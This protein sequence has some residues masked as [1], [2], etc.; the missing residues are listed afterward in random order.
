MF[1]FIISIFDVAESVLRARGV[2]TLE[3][4]EQCV[5]VELNG[6]NYRER[7]EEREGEGERES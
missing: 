5:L 2:K 3:I 1:D 7:E 4:I 6:G